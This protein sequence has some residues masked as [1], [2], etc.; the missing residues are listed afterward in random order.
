MKL[1]LVSLPLIASLANG[2]VIPQQQGP[3]AATALNDNVNSMWAF[4]VYGR[5]NGVL[6]SMEVMYGE[7]D[8]WYFNPQGGLSQ[9]DFYPQ[10]HAGNRLQ[11]TASTSGVPPPQ[12]PTAPQMEAAPQAPPLPAVEQSEPV[13]A[14]EMPKVDAQANV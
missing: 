11:T 1:Q 6:P 2:F 10:G 7:G 4:D 12:A 5:E 9:S 14:I 13:P 8:P 3:K